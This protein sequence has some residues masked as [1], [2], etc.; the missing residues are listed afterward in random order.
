[1]DRPLNRSTGYGDS[2]RTAELGGG[3]SGYQSRYTAKQRR[4]RG[5]A[6]G[7]P[8][9]SIHHLSLHQFGN[10]FVNVL[11]RPIFS[12]IPCAQKCTL[13]CLDCGTPKSNLKCGVRQRAS[14]R[15]WG[16]TRERREGMGRGLR[17]CWGNRPPWRPEERQTARESA[18]NP[19]WC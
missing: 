16:E 9:D 4:N 10:S 19:D 14:V 12:R 2:I 15:D 6:R 1:M 3:T 11:V 8:T 13:I 5:L 7:H 17:G 18:R